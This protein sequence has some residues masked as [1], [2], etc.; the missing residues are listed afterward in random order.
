[1]RT[2]VVLAGGVSEGD[3]LGVLPAVLGDVG[4]DDRVYVT[5]G[6]GATGLAMGALTALAQAGLALRLAG[7]RP[8]PPRVD[9]RLD[10]LDADPTLAVLLRWRLYGEALAHAM[11]GAASAVTEEQRGVLGALADRQQAGATTA[12]QALA[13]VA[14]AVVRRDG[15]AG[16]AVRRYVELGYRDRLAREGGAV[17][18]LQWAA[19]DLAASVSGKGRRGS[20]AVTLGPMLRHLARVSQAPPGHLRDE[21]RRESAGWLLGEQVRVLNELGSLSHE[22]RAPTITQADALGDVAASDPATTELRRAGLS[23]ATPRVARSVLVA[24]V[25]G[26][27]RTDET[28]PSIPRQLLV[29]GP[30][31]LVR[32]HVDPALVGGADPWSGL[33]LKVLLVVP[34]D[35]QAAAD[36]QLDELHRS[37]AT[38]VVPGG[39]PS[40]DGA[41][42][43]LAALHE[44]VERAVGESADDDVAAVVVMSAGR[45][46][47]LLALVQAAR[48]V[49]ARRGVPFFLRENLDRTQALAG[50][51]RV[52]RWPAV[53][54]GDRP[55]LHAARGCLESLE[56]DVAWRLLAA[57]CTTDGLAERCR[58]LADAFACREPGEAH[59]WP[60][61]FRG[62]PVESRTVGLLAQRLTLV[63]AGHRLLP[64]DVGD[65]AVFRMLVLA[66]TAIEVSAAEGLD[67]VEAREKAKR[68]FWAPHRE[69]ENDRQPESM[70]ARSLLVVRRVRNRTPLTHPPTN[71]QSPDAL[72]AAKAAD[73]GLAHLTTAA[74]LLD[75]APQAARDLGHGDGPSPT[76]VDLHGQLL[77]DLDA[78]LDTRGRSA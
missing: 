14:D 18:L 26:G 49:A 4:E 64:A 58:G 55:L 54:G 38:A 34:P 33:R 51:V 60:E 23:V 66:G 73:L 16:I 72:V 77:R 63:A 5:W 21:S 75:A 15:T 10:D 57:T 46:P 29:G 28:R 3:V 22:L 30:G 6:S 17:D 8:L 20:R 70:S 32:A 7:I 67:G 48:R 56:L 1:M 52:H 61:R 27:P 25:V 62:A 39:E 9:T 43:T 71:L 41:A 24:W 53:A 35:C 45:K 69:L 42:S 47:E 37:P 44:R 13:L 59:T 50:P 19:D 76:L 68:A 78:A 65:G 74:S 11:D 36:A 31:D 2:Q 40:A 12:G